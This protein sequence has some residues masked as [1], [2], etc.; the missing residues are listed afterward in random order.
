MKLL[1]VIFILI[2]MVACK[3]EQQPVIVPEC[4]L[5]SEEMINMMVDLTLVK[6]AKSVARQGLR[7]SGIKPMEYLYVKHGVDTIVIRENLE[8]YNSDL[9]KS[10]KLYEDVAS[11]LKKRQ[12]VLQIVID[13]LK[14]K[15]EK[16][17]EVD[18]D[19]EDEDEDEVPLDDE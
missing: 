13:T 6:S 9:K 3:K 5:S 18:L 8:Y 11:V 12:E 7:D 16:S 15:E 4:L 17:Q 1:R 2:I 19:E 14:K 10:K